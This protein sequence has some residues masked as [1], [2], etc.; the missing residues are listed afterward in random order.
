MYGCRWGYIC[1]LC[2]RKGW[3]VKVFL[4]SLDAIRHS[5]IKHPKREH[6]PT[7]PWSSV[8]VGL[9]RILIS[10]PQGLADEENGSNTSSG[11]SSIGSG[12]QQV[13]DE[14][15]AAVLGPEDGRSHQGA[16][17]SGLGGGERV[18]EGGLD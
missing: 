11:D 12:G 4:D 1:V 16:R 14:N 5:A 18:G 13:D 17:G 7:D 3:R 15:P 9:R 2:E 6:T 10:N 8:E